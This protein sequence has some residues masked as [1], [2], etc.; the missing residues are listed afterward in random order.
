[1]IL[2]I[3]VLSKNTRFLA[4][5]KRWWSR[6]RVW[7]QH[8]TVQHSKVWLK[9]FWVLFW[10]PTYTMKSCQAFHVLYQNGQQHSEG[11]N[12][13]STGQHAFI[14]LLQLRTAY[15]HLLCATC[16]TCDVYFPCFLS[17]VHWVG[18]QWLSWM[19]QKMLFQLHVSSFLGTLPLYSVTLCTGMSCDAL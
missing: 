19:R 4:L 8:K 9:F 10:G 6:N 13:R 11:K 2:G 18:V 12:W 17:P 7:W 14:L 1:M 15:Q 16:T 5:F 3:R